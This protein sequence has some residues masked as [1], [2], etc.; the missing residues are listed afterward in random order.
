MRNRLRQ[1]EITV[2]KFEVDVGAS[3]LRDERMVRVVVEQF[4]DRRC[5]EVF[6]K[7]LEAAADIRWARASSMDMKVFDDL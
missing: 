3:R 5:F 2:R 6:L 4:G 7:Q 1:I